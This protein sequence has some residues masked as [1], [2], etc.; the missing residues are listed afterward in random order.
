MPVLGLLMPGLKV[1]H[2]DSVKSHSPCSD[3]VSR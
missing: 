3:S 2:E 1:R